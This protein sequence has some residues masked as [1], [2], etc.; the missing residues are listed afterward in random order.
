MATFSSDPMKIDFQ[1]QKFSIVKMH[2]YMPRLTLAKTREMSDDS[3]TSELKVI[4]QQI[5]IVF[6]CARDRCTKAKQYQN[7]KNGVFHRIE[8]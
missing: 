5:D 3:N 6:D 1:N 7:V 8:T 2:L 4:L